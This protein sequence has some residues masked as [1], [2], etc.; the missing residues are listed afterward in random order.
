MS[1]NLD[2][3]TIYDIYGIDRKP[4]S[5]EYDKDSLADLFIEEWIPY[6]ECHK[7]GRSDYCKY[8]EIYPRNP[9]RMLD[10][11]CGVVVDVLKNFV[12]STFPKLETMQN[13]DKQSYL[14]GAFYLSQ[15][16]LESEGM[17]GMCMNSDF[18]NYF[19]DYSPSLFGRITHLR[20][21]LNLIGQSFK[22]IPDFH[23]NKGV[24]FVEGWSEKALFE[25]LRESHASWYTD[26][27]VEV[28]DGKDNKRPKRIEMLLQKYVENGYVI[29]IQ[30]D[31]DGKSQG[32]FQS[33]ID[34]G[35]VKEENTFVFDHDLETSVPS[36]VLFDAL[37]Q[38]GGL[39][40]IDKEE[41]VKRLEGSGE[42]VC[43]TLK[44]KLGIDVNPLKTRLAT[45]VGGVLNKPFWAWWQDDEFMETEFGRFMKF[46][47]GIPT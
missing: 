45:E 25:K 27:I 22:N 43:K 4:L 9:H 8:T 19:G 5:G 21:R 46:V 31:A 10:I 17:I 3:L 2:S 14:D 44:N 15:Y 29:Y 20:D 36:H 7:C 13:L 34:K 39:E 37:K 18:V 42:S 24:L 40:G 16:V 23:S 28:Y 1:V 32:I 30:G 6:Y 41:Y 38:C 26:L 12:T 47:W 33:L 11:K 35:L